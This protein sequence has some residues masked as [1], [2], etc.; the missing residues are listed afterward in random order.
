[1][2]LT[3][4]HLDQRPASAQDAAQLARFPQL[5]TLKL[6]RNATP[7]WLLAAPA[8]LTE[9]SLEQSASELDFLEL[10]SLPATFAALPSLSTLH[11]RAIFPQ[12]KWLAALAQSHSPPP[13]LTT[14]RLDFS[15]FSE[16]LLAD[17]GRL[18]P[19]RSLA[20]LGGLDDEAACAKL[21]ALT[22]VTE[23]HLRPLSCY[24]RSAMAS[25]C[26]ALPCLLTLRLEKLSMLE[27]KAPNVVQ[28]LAAS[29]SLRVLELDDFHGRDLPLAKVRSAI[30]PAVEVRW[31]R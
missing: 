1:M 28:R 26:A 25:A 22:S 23:L 13:A 4:L 18:S 24:D 9:L 19:V 11:V 20:L 30:G 3:C 2:P 15:S 17:L 8:S 31:L 14:L 10:L 16:E 6:S 27:S 12:H 7:G 5:T 29:T 21:S